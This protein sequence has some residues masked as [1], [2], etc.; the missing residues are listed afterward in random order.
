MYADTRP[1]YPVAA[2]EAIEAVVPSP[3]RVL[4]VGPGP[5][6]A[7]IPLAERGYAVVGIE[8]GANLARV[9][10]TRVVAFPKVQ[11]VHADFELWRPEPPGGFDLVLAA[12]SWHWIDPAVAYQ[13][14]HA[15]LRPGGWLALLANHPRPGR[16]GS[17]S[18][19]FWQA[20]DGIYQALAPE[21]V[22]RR[23]WSP[24]RLP[25]RSSEITRSGLFG[26]VQ[27]HTWRWRREFTA[28]AYLA[29]LDTYSDH[30]TLPARQRRRLF[31][32]IRRLIVQG[33]AGVVSREYET[34][35]YLA[36][37]TPG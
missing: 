5:G 11:I 8:L 26:P 23:G 36:A 10:R 27:R 35:L 30:R 7:T 4:E 2:F 13:Q 24:S 29:L 18:R 25:N 17:R 34:Q 14:A 31:V 32:A 37:R 16:P 6:V 15:A 1:S 22:A 19:A 21:L 3:A 20:T 28:D 9:A 12:S 33:F